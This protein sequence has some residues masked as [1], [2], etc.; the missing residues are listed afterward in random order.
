MAG[1]KTT[2]ETPI[3]PPNISDYSVEMTSK[4]PGNVADS[5]GLS[6]TTTGFRNFNMWL[7]GAIFPRRDYV[8][9]E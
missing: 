6:P 9:R 1:V 2:L 7:G 3:G 8:A 5:S 4:Y